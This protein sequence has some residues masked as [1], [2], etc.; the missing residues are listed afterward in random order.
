MKLRLLQNVMIDGVVQP[1]GSVIDSEA[2]GVN[3]ESMIS[4]NWAEPTDA[5]VSS[6]TV[7]AT[8]DEASSDE[9]PAPA[10]AKPKRTR[11]S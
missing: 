4:W 6:P 7:D 1:F 5:D 8:P 9:P 11:K 10:P 3:P 2:T